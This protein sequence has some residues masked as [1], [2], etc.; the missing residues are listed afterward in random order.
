MVA[1]TGDVTEVVDAIKTYLEEPDMGFKAVYWGDQMLVPTSPAAAIEPM[2]ASRTLTETGLQARWDFTI[3]I[4]LYTAKLGKTE[5]NRR[6]AGV[7]ARRVV[8]KFD[9]TR[10]LGGIVVDGMITRVEAGFGVRNSQLF[11]VVRCTW[12]GFSKIIMPAKTGA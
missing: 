6:D 12:E 11:R 3:A 1:L 2:D 4:I 9:L 5:E 7:I 10:T 8:D